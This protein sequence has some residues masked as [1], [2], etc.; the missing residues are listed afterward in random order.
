MTTR[1]KQPT[2]VFE[3]IVH[4]LRL[5]DNKEMCIAYQRRLL[6]PL[7]QDML[8]SFT[9]LSA[10]KMSSIS[11]FD[12]FEP[13]TRPRMSLQFSRPRSVTRYGRKFVLVAENHK[14]AGCRGLDEVFQFLGLR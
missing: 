7:Q 3:G 11:N 14:H 5:H 9:S 10:P 2:C 8:K 1:P 4:K 6:Q 13:I 12:S